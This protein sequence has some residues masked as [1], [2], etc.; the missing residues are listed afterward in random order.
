MVPIAFLGG[1]IVLQAAAATGLMIGSLSAVAAVSPSDSFLWMGGGL[2]IGLTCLVGA[3]FASMFFPGSSILQNV[4]L[5][6]GLGL[7]GAMTLYDTQKVVQKAKLQTDENFDPIGD[8]LGLFLNT[9][10]VFVRMVQIFSNQSNNN[11]RR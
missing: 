3:S 11:R 2:S 6:G 1:P 7:F 5:Y 4:A 8:S 10:N 9:V